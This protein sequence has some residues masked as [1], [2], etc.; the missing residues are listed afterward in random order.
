[1]FHQLKTYFKLTFFVFIS[2]TKARIFFH[3][4]RLR[5]GCPNT[6]RRAAPADADSGR[7]AARARGRFGQAAAH[8]RGQNGRRQRRKVSATQ[9]RAHAS[10]AHGENAGGHTGTSGTTTVAHTTVTALALLGLVTLDAGA[11]VHGNS[12]TN[13]NTVLVEL[14]DV[15]A[16]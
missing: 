11:R 10:A 1:M 16:Y 3:P 6:P 12:T 15:L 9:P 5:N 8:A 4:L 14:A 2:S 13:N 7:E